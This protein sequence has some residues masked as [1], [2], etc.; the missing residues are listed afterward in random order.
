PQ[1]AGARARMASGGVPGGRSGPERPDGSAL[2]GSNG[3][4][5]RNTR[6]VRGQGGRRR[7]PRDRLRFIAL[8]REPPVTATRDRQES[9]SPS[10]PV[11]GEDGRPESPRENGQGGSDA[12]GKLRS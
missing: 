4:G 7:Q 1:P 9:D 5:Q 8:R 11:P 3:G 12:T 2:E 6:G 10:H